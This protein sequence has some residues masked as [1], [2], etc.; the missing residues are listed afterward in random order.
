MKLPSCTTFG[1]TKLV[2]R[3]ANPSQSQ[4]SVSDATR[5]PVS[6][7]ASARTEA[8]MSSQQNKEP[9][10]SVLVEIMA[11]QFSRPLF[12]VGLFDTPAFLT[13]YKLGKHCLSYT[14]CLNPSF[15]DAF[16]FPKTWVYCSHLAA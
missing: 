16:R 12:D 2:A 5:F 9:R 6:C 4:P 11:E 3:A 15:R 1:A 10:E 13:D 14:I 7:T 8:E